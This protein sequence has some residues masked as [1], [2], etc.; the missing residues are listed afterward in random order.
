MKQEQFKKTVFG[1][2]ITMDNKFKIILFLCN[3]APHTAYQSLQDKGYQIPPEVKMVRIPCT[4]RISKALLFKA[5][6]MGAD[7]VALVGC[8]PGAC[9]YGAG[10]TAA[11]KNTEDTG[12]ILEL[13]GLGKERMKLATFLPDESEALKTFLADFCDDIRKLGKSRISPDRRGMS[14]TCPRY[15][16]FIAYRIKVL[17]KRF[18]DSAELLLFFRKGFFPTP[19]SVCQHFSDLPMPTDSLRPRRR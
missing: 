10:T 11:V 1:T 8:S 15:T 2:K 18:R 13:L 5:F 7:G 9:R 4:G 12:A 19:S 3:W 14:A 16:I 6:E 17:P